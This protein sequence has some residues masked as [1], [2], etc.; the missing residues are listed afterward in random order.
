MKRILMAWLLGLFMLSPAWAL[1]SAEL[2]GKYDIVKGIN[3]DGSTYD[4]SVVVKADVSGGVSVTWDDGSVGVGMIDG[5]KLVIGMV[6]EK[7]SVVMTMDVGK[8]GT[9]NGKWIQRTTTG[10]GVE[11][12]KKK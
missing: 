10:S 2:V 4:G 5:N 9:L 11:I 3:P 8:D 7:R 12:W 6:F 1:S